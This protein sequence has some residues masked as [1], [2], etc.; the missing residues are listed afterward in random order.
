MTATRVDPTPPRVSSAF[1]RVIE[2]EPRSP[3]Q[4]AR[5]LVNPRFLSIN[6]VPIRT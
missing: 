3:K 5:V 6:D 1:A 4:K 2:I